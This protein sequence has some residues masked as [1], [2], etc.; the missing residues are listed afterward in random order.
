[1]QDLLRLRDGPFDIRGGG[2]GLGFLKK[3]QGRKKYIFNEVKNKR[4]VLHSV[5]FFQIPFPWEL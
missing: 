1:M 4:F 3:K 5:N 2:A